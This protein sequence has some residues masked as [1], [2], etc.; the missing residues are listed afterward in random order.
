MPLLNGLSRG[1]SADSVVNNDDGEGFGDDFAGD[2]VALALLVDHRWYIQLDP[3]PASRR[4]CQQVLRA[5][6]SDTGRPEGDKT[7][8]DTDT[9][10]S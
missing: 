10:I 3:G 6:K 2:H 9:R 1:N 8:P 4:I 7:P 5:A